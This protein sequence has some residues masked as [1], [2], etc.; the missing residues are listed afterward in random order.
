M[1]KNFLKY[2]LAFLMKFTFLNHIKIKKIRYRNYFLKKYNSK[3]KIKNKVVLEYLDRFNK[4]ERFKNN[5][6][7]LVLFF[8]KKAVCFGWLS[9]KVNME[10]YR[11]KQNNI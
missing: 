5:E 9:K 11:N 3:K 7:L 10:N 2:L 4:F 1:I 8:K 6:T